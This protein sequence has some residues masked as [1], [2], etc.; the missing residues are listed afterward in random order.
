LLKYDI[1]RVTFK[2][3]NP[4]S[5]RPWGKPFLTVRTFPV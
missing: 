5:A 4:E 1:N 3:Q 2:H